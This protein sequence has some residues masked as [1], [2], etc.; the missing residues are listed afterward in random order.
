M[1]M[2]F[3]DYPFEIRLLDCSKLAID[4][5][6]NNDVII[7]WNDV[8]VKFFDVVLFLLSSLVTGLSFL[9]KSLLV[10]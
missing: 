1:K 6:K 10:L 8:I 4:L 2:K 9:S 7:C 3:T 5:K